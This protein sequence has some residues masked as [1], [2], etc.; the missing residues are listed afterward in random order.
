M[1][2]VRPVVETGYENIVQV[3][4]L[5]EGTRPEDMLAHWH[6]ML[7]EAMQRF[8]Q[9]SRGRARSRRGASGHRVTADSL[10]DLRTG[11]RSWICSG[12]L[13]TSGSRPTWRGG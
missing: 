3:R 5:L 10:R 8:G 6:A 4:L 12:P 9:A 2:I 13:A 11:R 7:P 1:R